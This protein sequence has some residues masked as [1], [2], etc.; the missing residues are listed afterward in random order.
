M[1]ELPSKD[2]NDAKPPA[3]HRF[4]R[5]AARLLEVPVLLVSMT[6][7]ERKPVESCVGTPEPWASSQEVSFPDSFYEHIITYDESLIVEN[8]REDERVE[9]K[10][11]F[12]KMGITAYAAVPLITP[13][14]HVMGTLCAVDKNPRQWAEAEMELLKDLSAAVMARVELKEA[15]KEA[16]RANREKS[17]FLANVSHEL[18]TPLNA[19][20]G[21]T[22]L[23]KKDVEEVGEEHMLDDLDEIQ[24]AGE[25]LLNLINDV[26]DLSKIESGELKVHSSS[27][28][29][30]EMI[31]K[32]AGTAEPLLEKND[33]TLEVDCPEGIGTMHADLPKVRQALFNLLSNAAKFTEGG[34]ITMTARREEQEGE[35]WLILS[36]Q[37]TGI[38]M[39]EEEQEDIFEEFAQVDSSLTREKGGTGLGLAITFNMCKMMGGEVDVESEKDAGSTFTLRLPAYIE[40][41]SEDAEPARMEPSDDSSDQAESTKSTVL[42]IDDEASARNLIER[43][44]QQEGSFAVHTASTGEE[45]LR[46][47]RQLKP[48]AMLQEVRERIAAYRERQ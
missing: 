6:D 44:L 27:F 38:G 10:E 11:L 15:K 19:V 30:S 13:S 39:T 8:A 41:P 20:L 24:R 1:A 34:T 31:G 14:G 36:V 4:T 16:E 40:A 25:Q 22:R 23:L 47:A 35:D 32:V 42:V 48:E 12:H 28:D 18:R 45:G 37:D 7:R 3:S 21:Y 2:V 26:L 17:H 46:M 33:N 9:D 43:S 5:L 29:V